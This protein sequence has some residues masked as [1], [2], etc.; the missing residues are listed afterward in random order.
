MTDPAPYYVD[1]YVTLYLGDCL[2]I[3][4]WLAGDV[5]VTDPP[6]GVGAALSSGGKGRRK[7]TGYVPTHDRD[8]GWDR[9]LDVRNAALERWGDRPFAVFGSP[10]RLDDRPPCREQPLIWDKGDSVGM[11]DVTFPWRPNYELVYVNGAGW[12]GHRGSAVLRGHPLSHLDAR[13]VGHPTPKPLGLM[14]AIIDKAP[15]GVIVD[16][17]AGSGSTLV[18][19]KRAGR[20][21]I[22]VELEEKYAAIIAGRLSQ[23]VLD[24]GATS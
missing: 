5:L 2:T 19:A 8:V 13:D 4:A 1:D 22:G 12:S 21:A 16:P 17:F 3:D 23:G 24:F 6:Y 15:E 10:K 9:T 11:G 14:G 20:R 7:P 18:A